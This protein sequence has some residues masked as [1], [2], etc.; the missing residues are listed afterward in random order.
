MEGHNNTVFG[1]IIWY[2]IWDGI[3]TGRVWGVFC[4]GLWKMKIGAFSM[5]ELRLHQIWTSLNVALFRPK[6]ALLKADIRSHLSQLVY[7]QYIIVRS[8]RWQKADKKRVFGG[9]DPAFKSK[10]CQHDYLYC[11]LT[12]SGYHFP[13]KEALR[14]FW[15]KIGIHTAVQN[16]RGPPSKCGPAPGSFI[17]YPEIEPRFG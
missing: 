11:F 7:E 4:A 16:G 14:G 1:I 13:Q 3:E 6:H 2:G 10:Q 9:S 12:Q 17:V 5:S 15:Y 8:S